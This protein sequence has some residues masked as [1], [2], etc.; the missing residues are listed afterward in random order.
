MHSRC[1]AHRNIRPENILIS[2]RKIMISG[3]GASAPYVSNSVDDNVFESDKAYSR[4]P[5]AAPEIISNG[6][7]YL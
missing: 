1:I 7:Y 5:Y 3:L 4:E 6:C 2:E